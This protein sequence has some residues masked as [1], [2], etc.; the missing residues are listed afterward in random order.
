MRGITFSALALLGAF[1]TANTFNINFDTDSSGGAISDL[2]TISNQ[3]AGWG[4]NFTPN[5]YTGDTWATNTDMV[6]TSTSVGIGYPT[7]Q[8]NVLHS[9]DGWLNEDNDPSFAMVMSNADPVTSITASFIADSTGVSFMEAFHFDG[10]AYVSLGSVLVDGSSDPVKTVS[11]SGF[12]QSIDLV[13]FA[14]GSFND[15]AGVD[16]I[17]VTTTAVPEPASMLALGLGAVALIRRRK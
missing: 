17:I 8:G 15:W 14:P 7:A 9:F 6:A 1:A 12:S 3:Y 4:F 11:L 5:H 16:D 2:T 10:A 13:A